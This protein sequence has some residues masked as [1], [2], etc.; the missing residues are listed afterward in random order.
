M[1]TP[2][3]TEIRRLIS[4]AGPMPVAQYMALCLSHPERGYYMTRDP[5]GAAGDFTTAPEISQMF[6]E[7]IGL[8]AA[9]VWRLM[10]S[11]ARIHL[12]ELGPG[13]GT[14]MRDAL[15]A[16]QVVPGFVPAAEIHLVEVSPVLKE[17]QH[18]TLASLDARLHWHE[19]LNDV[20]DGPLIIMA[21][22]FFD[23]LP[24]HQAVKRADGWH[25]R[26]V[27][28]GPAGKLAFGIAA[29]PI[30]HFERILPAALRAAPPDTLFEWR[31]DH[32]ALEI[33]R[34]VARFNGAA[35]AIDY[36]HARSEAG[37]TLQAVGTHSYADPL[38]LP[39]SVDLT[40]HVDFQALGEAAESMGARVHGPVEQGEFLR[41][42][43]IESRA[44]ALKKSITADKVVDIDMA[45]ARLVEED[46]TAMGRL[47]K[48]IAFANAKLGPLPGFAG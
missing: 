39:G 8:W 4:V 19:S 48:A 12:V 41:R 45:M 47:F 36:G 10:E 37:D 7:L 30:R 14:M 16:A 43:G 17:R 20:P 23:A 28:V 11:P 40:A 1:A 38:K 13:R 22:E 15:R 2:V 44:A 35:L 32:V 33:G 26:V 21:N 29:E 9:S 24:V 25:E 46:D 5:L 3:E 27:E 18:H 34:R 31:N 6:G 42:L